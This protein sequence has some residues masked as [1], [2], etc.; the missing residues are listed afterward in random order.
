MRGLTEALSIYVVDDDDAVRDSLA[1]LLEPEGFT[2]RQFSSVD[3]FLEVLEEDPPGDGGRACLLLDLHMPGKGGQELLD[4]LGRRESRLPVVVMTG[5]T[6]EKTRAQALLKGAV[7]FL[8]KPV[9]A[10]RL[11]ATLRD[12]LG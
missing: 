9:D 4:I 5:N 6:D 3:S 7:A 11:I 12:A 1:V 2:V 10:D 8:E